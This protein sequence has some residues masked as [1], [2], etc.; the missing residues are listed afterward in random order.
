MTM[1]LFSTFESIFDRKFRFTT[2]M[3]CDLCI[4]YHL[5]VFLLPTSSDKGITGLGECYDILIER[6]SGK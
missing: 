2:T 4:H 3:A 5:S 6:Y 1:R